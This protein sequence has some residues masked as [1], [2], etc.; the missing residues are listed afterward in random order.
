[1][2]Q[3]VAAT[4]RAARI[5]TR[6]EWNARALELAEAKHTTGT[7]R[8]IGTNEDGAHLYRVPSWSHDGAVYVGSVWPAGAVLCCCTSASYSRPCKHA[9]AALHAE[10]QRE[11]AMTTPQDE[12]AR[13]YAHGGQR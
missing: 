7:A 2:T 8:H 12:P 13:W 3:A 10:R 11:A 1:M 9:G 4:A 6:A 5:R